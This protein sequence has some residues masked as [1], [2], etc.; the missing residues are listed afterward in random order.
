MAVRVFA[1]PVVNVRLHVPVATVPEHCA[2]A[3]SLTVTVPVGVPVPG[4][5]A[6]TLKFTV[7][8]CPVT[9]GSGSSRVVA[10]VVAALFTVCGAGADAG[11]A[12]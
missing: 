1:P 12:R 9:E 8:A 7:T 10:V 2:P 3:P 11:L 4:A 6:T 5:V